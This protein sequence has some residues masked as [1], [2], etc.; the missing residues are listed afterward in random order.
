MPWYCCAVDCKNIQGKSGYRFYRFPTEE[1]QRT[2]WIAA[3][4]RANWTPYKKCPYKHR[5]ISPTSV[6]ALS[7]PNFCLKVDDNERIVLSKKHVYYTQIQGQLL[8][9][10][11]K[12]CDFI[13]WTTKGVFVETIGEDVNLQSEIIDKCKH[14]FITY[15]I[16]ELLTHRLKNGL[17]ISSELEKTYCFCG[18]GEEGLMIACDNPSCQLEW[19]HYKCVNIKRKPKGSWYCN[20]KFCFVKK[21]RIIN[22]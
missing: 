4:N 20:N 15:I 18:K 17:Q 22:Q 5:N 12:T 1:R 14:F 16:P 19:F 7:D 9:S 13:C 3:I 6:S 2:S 11:Y 8:V 10:H 21:S